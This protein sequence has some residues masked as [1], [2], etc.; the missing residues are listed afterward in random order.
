MPACGNE[1]RHA[2]MQGP[3]RLRDPP[4]RDRRALKV[5]APLEAHPHTGPELPLHALR[6][7]CKQAWP[8]VVRV[9]VDQDHLIALLAPV[10]DHLVAPLDQDALEGDV[11]HPAHKLRR[12][13]LSRMDLPM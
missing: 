4:G 10:D 3:H 6:D 7:L 9:L 11:L 5:R 8:V 13:V 2:G 12:D 1:Q